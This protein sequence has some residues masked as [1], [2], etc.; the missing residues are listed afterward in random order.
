MSLVESGLESLVSAY[1]YLVD[2]SFLLHS[3][4]YLNAFFAGATQHHP[5]VNFVF[6]RV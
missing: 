3:S 5:R 2:L 4:V 1:Y 6:R